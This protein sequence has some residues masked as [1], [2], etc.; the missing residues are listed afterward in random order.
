MPC[1]M[2]SPRPQAPEIYTT[3][4]AAT[5]ERPASW[6]VHTS[7][8]QASWQADTC[9]TATTAPCQSRSLC[10]RRRSR[11]SWPGLSAP[12]SEC[13][14]KD[15]LGNGQSLS[16]RASETKAIDVM[17][18]DMECRQLTGWVP[19]FSRYAIALLVNREAMHRLQ[20]IRRSSPPKQHML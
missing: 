4:E 11:R 2:F 20:A 15:R 16:G 3:C 8:R 18:T 9:S 12:S 7:W 14:R 1:T 13:R 5:Y 17:Q 6:Q 10:P 19:W